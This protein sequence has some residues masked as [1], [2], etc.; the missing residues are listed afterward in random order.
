MAYLDLSV[1]ERLEYGW[2]AAEWKT[3]SSVAQ[4]LKP[5]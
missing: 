5:Y 4:S 2:S 3:F 1:G